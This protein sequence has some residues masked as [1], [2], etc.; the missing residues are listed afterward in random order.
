MHQ[1]FSEETHHGVGLI[2]AFIRSVVSQGLI[3]PMGHAP[4]PIFR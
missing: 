1:P 4:V 2:D 3:Q